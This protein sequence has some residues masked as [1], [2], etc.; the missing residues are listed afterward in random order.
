MTDAFGVSGKKASSRHSS[1]WLPTK[2]NHQIAHL[3]PISLTMGEQQAAS[4]LAKAAKLCKVLI[5]GA[6][7]R[8]LLSPLDFRSGSI[9]TVCPSAGE[10]IGPS[11][12]FSPWADHFWSSPINRHSQGSSAYPK[13]A[14][15]YP[16]V[17]RPPLS[18]A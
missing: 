16:I 8:T 10:E 12:S 11:A 15:D 2:D 7:G 9:A 4:E 6:I 13:S 5:S 14:S 17:A 18:R 1:E 3:I